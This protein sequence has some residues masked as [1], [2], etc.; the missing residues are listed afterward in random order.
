MTKG[1]LPHLST[2]NRPVRT[3]HNFSQKT[4]VGFRRFAPNS[5]QSGTHPIPD[6]G[7]VDE[8]RPLCA[9]LQHSNSL[10]LHVWS[11]DCFPTAITIPLSTKGVVNKNR[12]WTTLFT[13]RPKL[14]SACLVGQTLIR[15]KWAGRDRSLSKKVWTYANLRARWISGVGSASLLHQFARLG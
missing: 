1:S 6:L 7:L 5:C 8:E 13:D 12:I 11:S 3:R 2:Q 14:E 4:N 10:P 9:Q 15:R